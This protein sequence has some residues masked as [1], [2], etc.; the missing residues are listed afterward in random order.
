M[1]N[2][3]LDE[4]QLL[5]LLRW[6]VCRRGAITFKDMKLVCS[7]CTACFPLAGH[8]HYDFTRFMLSGHRRLFN[9]YAEIDAGLVAGPATAF[10]WALENIVLAFSSLPT[11]RKV[12][13]AGVRFG[14]GWIKYLDYFLVNRPEAMDGASCTYF[15]GSKADIRI[16]DSEFIA[17]YVGAKHL[18]HV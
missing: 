15:M 10:V 14:F 5:N 11:T 8:P 9:Q 17:R 13:K 18:R 4:S 7:A 1:N 6:P 2:A 12:A 16:T 3:L